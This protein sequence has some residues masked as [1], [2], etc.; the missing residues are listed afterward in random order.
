MREIFAAHFSRYPTLRPQD[1]VKLAYQSVYG[2]GH[3]ISDPAQ[4]ANRLKEEFASSTPAD[5]P[6]IEDIG[7]GRARLHLNSTQCRKEWIDS[8]AFLFAEGAKRISTDKSALDGP[9]T[10]LRSM[11]EAGL[12]PFSLEELEAY[13]TQYDAAG[14]PMVSHTET[15]RKAYHPAYRVMEKTMLRLLPLFTAIDKLLESDSPI[16]VAIDG[17]A[18]AG[19]STLGTLLQKRYG[20]NLI[21]MDDFF[22]PPELRTPERFATP[23]GN[24]HYERFKEQVQQGLASGKPFSYD[25]FNCHEMACTSQNTVMQNHLTVVEGSYSLHPTLRDFYTLKVFYPID[26]DSQLERIRVRNGEE[27]ML[28]YR[29][30]WIPLENEYITAC[31]VKACANLIL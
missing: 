29:D 12:A 5:I 26:A 4:A 14:R 6:F 16:S 27:C 25:V 17:M 19:K 7:N 1:A 23:G 28:R 10:D 11:A 15:Y 24:V 18:A 2:A 9:I 20:C 21:H 30:R 8:I 31:G 3:L 13:L 22:L